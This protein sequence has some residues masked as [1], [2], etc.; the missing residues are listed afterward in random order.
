VLAFPFLRS[1]WISLL[2]GVLALAAGVIAG[3][4]A[5][6]SPWLLWLVQTRADRFMVD[7][8]PLV[9]WFGFALVGVFFGL[10]LYPGGNRAV[11]LPELA[12]ALPIRGLAFLGR[13]SLPIYLVHQPILL[14][15]LILL[16]IGSF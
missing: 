10:T 13:H 16:G 4:H 7:W 12:Q 2:V 11:R 5:L 8:Y 15:L 14:G 3:D 9:P 1:R 6:P